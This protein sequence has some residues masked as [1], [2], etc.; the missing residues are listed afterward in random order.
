[1]VRAEFVRIALQTAVIST[2]LT[3]LYV[4]FALAAVRWL[5]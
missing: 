3:V 5:G 4:A 2:V 1:M